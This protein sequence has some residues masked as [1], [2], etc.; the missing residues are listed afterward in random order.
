M[1][2]LNY[3][4]DVNQSRPSR[5]ADLE[6]NFD[7]NDASQNKTRAFSSRTC[8]VALALGSAIATMGAL[9]YLASNQNSVQP[10]SLSER[11]I[12]PGCLNTEQFTYFTGIHPFNDNDND[13]YCTYTDKTL[14]EQMAELI[15]H[16]IISVIEHAGNII[17]HGAKNTFECINQG[18]TW[19]QYIDE[20]VC[21]RMDADTCSS[22]GGYTSTGGSICSPTINLESSASKLC[23]RDLVELCKWQS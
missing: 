10:S 1:H 14:P 6:Q 5:L 13:I 19:R 21:V 2:N 18:L 17:Y 8:V 15:N 11:L 7:Q 22:L 23:S 12:T 16:G 20:S 4:A 9:Y 3:R